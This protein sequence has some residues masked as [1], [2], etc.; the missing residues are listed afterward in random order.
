MDTIIAAD[1]VSKWYGE[2]VGLNNFSVSVQGGITGLVGPNGAGK[3]TFI[4]L[5][6]GQCSPHKGTLSVMGQDPFDNPPLMARIGYCPEH[7]ALYFGMRDIEFLEM[8]ARLRGF[9]KDAASERAARC[10][11]TVGLDPK[12]RPIGTF[13]K[14]MKQRL[15]IAQA[16]LHEP[17]LLILDEPFSGVDPLVRVKLYE[18]IRSLADRGMHVVLSSH[19]LYEVERLATTVVLMSDGK[20]IL[21]GDVDE[22]L[23]TIEHHTHS[24]RLETAEPSRLGSE[25]MGRGLIHSAAAV[26]GGLVVKTADQQRFFDELPSLVVKDGL[27]IRGLSP[28]DNDL[29]ALFDRLVRK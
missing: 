10:L 18:L 24:V 19:I 22:I 14:G 11:E 21:E 17:S 13:S 20:M 6:T 16:L 25:L 12:D 4:R 5:I 27:D 7:E 1:H 15:K 2:V 8:I 9:G 3:T 26:P 23:G 29:H 28:V